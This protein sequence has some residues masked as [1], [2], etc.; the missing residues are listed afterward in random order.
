MEALLRKYELLKRNSNGTRLTYSP[1]RLHGIDLDKMDKHHR[2]QDETVIMLFNVA[3]TNINHRKTTSD[4]GYIKT[5]CL[6]SHW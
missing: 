4:Q 6:S 2:V 5:I 1:R 3:L